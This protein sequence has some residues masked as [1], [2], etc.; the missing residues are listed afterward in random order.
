MFISFQET[1]V[2]VFD[3]T[4]PVVVND[5]SDLRALNPAHILYKLPFNAVP[6]PKTQSFS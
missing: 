6:D 2:Q 3:F 5:G 1:T 4:I